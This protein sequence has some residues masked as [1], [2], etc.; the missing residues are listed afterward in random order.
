[1]YQ[2]LVVSALYIAIKI[3]ER[4]IFSAENLAAVSQGIYSAE[5]I[6]AM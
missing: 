3:N 6:E 4:V 2:L 5:N 1:M